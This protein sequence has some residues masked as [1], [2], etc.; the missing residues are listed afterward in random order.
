MYNGKR[1]CATIE[2]RMTSSRLPGKVLKPYCG[3]PNL[4][5][6]IE[7]LMRS[8]YIDDV[9]VAT[10][11]N[12]TDTPI[13]ELCQQIGCS[14]FR[15]SEED[16]LLRVLGAA[17][18]VHADV[19]VEITGDCPVIDWRHTDELVAFF[20]SGDYDYV[21]N[22][23]T[24]TYP[25]GFDTQVFP[26]SVLNRVNALTQSPVDH[27]H[28]SLYIYTHPEIFRLGS[29]EAPEP[30]RHAELGITLDN[31]DDYALICE[32]YQRLYPGNP[33][34]SGQDVV[35][36]ILADP[37]LTQRAQDRHR[38]DPFAEQK[39]WADSHDGQ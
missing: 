29:M 37:Q 26:V 14:C 11:V 32:L 7:R 22:I 33:D 24:R 39:A 35:D 4:Q 10:T 23:I 34:F 18:S 8:R 9:V 17:Q 38:K 3:K 36:C 21:S 27:E 30:M 13:V 20:F 25:R 16:V 1:I 15:G 19:I 6:I 12:E 2:A 28:V 31:A 5:H